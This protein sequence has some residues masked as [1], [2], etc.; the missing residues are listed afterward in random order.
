MTVGAID[1]NIRRTATPWQELSKRLATTGSS[2][3]FG[4]GWSRECGRVV[5]KVS[6]QCWKNNSG[7]G[8]GSCRPAYTEL[9]FGISSGN[10]NET[11]AEKAL[12]AGTLDIEGKERS[13]KDRNGPS[14]C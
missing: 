7:G 1:G 6:A 11:W 14:T 9:G 8:S 10:D 13:I 12:D 5:S 3:E 4:R 2:R